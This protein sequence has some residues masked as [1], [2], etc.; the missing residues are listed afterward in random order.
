MATKSHSKLSI[1]PIA[2]ALALLG[3]AAIP[4]AC[5]GPSEP[6]PA[7]P[8][9]ALPRP[10]ATAPLAQPTGQTAPHGAAPTER[11]PAAAPAEGES[12]RWTVPAAWTVAPNPSTMR[13]A[14]YKIAKAAGGTE[15]AECFVIMAGGTA[16]ANVQR[17]EGQFGGSKAKLDKKTVNGIEVTIVEI[18]GSFNAGPMMGGA[19]G[20]RPDFA[21]LAVIAAVANGESYFFKLTGEKKTVLA[22]RADFDKLV[23]SFARP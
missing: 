18:E 9:P 17:W 23:G 5:D 14:T 2:L 12:L 4:F 19:A 6:P 10:G 16:E 22:A 20:P 1:T 15:D 3:A 13:K 11:G 21:M 7:L 8:K